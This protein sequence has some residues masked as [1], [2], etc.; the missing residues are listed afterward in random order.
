MPR[1]AHP[2]IFFADL[3]GF[4]GLAVRPGA[5]KARDVLSHLA[6]LL[7]GADEL[8][9][10]VQSPVWSER[11]GLS[12]SIFLV[13]E[14]LGGGCVAASELFFALA[15]VQVDQQ[16]PVFLRGALTFGEAYRVEPLFPES[17][18]ANLVGQGVVD[19]VRLESTL[20]GPRLQVSDQLVEELRSRREVQP[21]LARTQTGAWEILWPLGP[22]VSRLNAT[23]VGEICGMAARL[24]LAAAD[25]QE[26]RPH[27]EGLLELALSSLEWLGKN[28]PNLV[29][30]AQEA[31]ELVHRR[32]ALQRELGTV[33]A[34]RLDELLQAGPPS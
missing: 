8:A 18:T 19:A 17:A 9:G 20:K 1:N 13:T 6:R 25:S 21:V 12:D 32:E 30:M 23:M 14:N 4:G 29:A 15:Y 11:Y 7:S 16:A 26:L 31:S 10:L 5:D 33:Q 24:F 2:L 27:Y 34:R 28:K 3:L 22:T